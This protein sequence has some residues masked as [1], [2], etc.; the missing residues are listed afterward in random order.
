[1]SL[2]ES[3]QIETLMKQHMLVENIKWKKK[4]Q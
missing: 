4:W 3:I 2:N 1:M